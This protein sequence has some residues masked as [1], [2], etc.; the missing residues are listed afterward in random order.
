MDCAAGVLTAPSSGCEK[1]MAIGDDFWI[2]D[3]DGNKV[4]KVD[5]KAVRLRDTF[6]LEDAGRQRAV[7]DPGEEAQRPRQDDDR[8][9]QHQGDGAQAPRGH[10]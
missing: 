3:D 5:G 6:I 1:I 2:E 9:G 10:P 7:E 4:F 8:A